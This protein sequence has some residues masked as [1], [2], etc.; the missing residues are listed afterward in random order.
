MVTQE[1]DIM[2]TADYFNRCT[3]WLALP[4]DEQVIL[5]LRPPSEKWLRI[6]M[7]ELRPLI[8]RI[9]D[10]TE[11]ILKRISVKSCDRCNKYGQTSCPNPDKYHI[12]GIC[13]RFDWA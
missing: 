2:M 12:K 13:G 7:R 3:E 1:L 10:E 4:D 11:I 6:P 5:R 9:A 8:E